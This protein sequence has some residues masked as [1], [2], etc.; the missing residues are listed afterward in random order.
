MFPLHSLSCPLQTGLLF[1]TKKDVAAVAVQNDEG[2]SGEAARVEI[3]LLS[4]L[5]TPDAFWKDKKPDK[6]DVDFIR[7]RVTQTFR[8]TGQCLVGW[9]RVR[10]NTSDALSVQ[11]VCFLFLSFMR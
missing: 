7:K 6:L 8:A 3:A 11:E 5:E 9:F 1:G 4:F 2:N 10:S